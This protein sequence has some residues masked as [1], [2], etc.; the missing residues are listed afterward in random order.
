MSKP[1]RIYCPFNRKNRFPGNGDTVTWFKPDTCDATF[2]TAVQL[3]VARLVFCCNANP[4]KAADHAIA[5]L[6]VPVFAMDIPGPRAP[7]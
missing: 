2:V 6:F 7:T 5:A 3:V 4:A 1:R